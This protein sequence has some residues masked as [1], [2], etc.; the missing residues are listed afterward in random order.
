MSLMLVCCLIRPLWQQRQTRDGQLFSYHRSWKWN[1]SWIDLNKQKNDWTDLPE[2]SSS[3]L[4]SVSVYS[5]SVTRSRRRSWGSWGSR[6]PRKS[7]CSWQMI[8]FT[9]FRQ[10]FG[11]PLMG[12]WR[13]G[14]FLFMLKHVVILWQRFHPQRS[15]EQ[16][17]D[18]IHYSSV[19]EISVTVFFFN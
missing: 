4:G 11:N 18:F 8:T 19:N 16:P 15:S 17:D 10:T 13:K 2:G 12:R 9:L 3:D 6:T 7:N 5:W 1:M 14:S